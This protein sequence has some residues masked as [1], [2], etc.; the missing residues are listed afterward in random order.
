MMETA[1]YYTFSTIA[2]TL[3]AAIALLAAFLLYRLQTIAH[4]IDQHVNKLVQF[5]GGQ[6]RLDLDELD[7]QGKHD[8]FLAYSR[9]HHTPAV[10][11][12]VRIPHLRL[13]ALL[14]YRRAI[15][16][17]FYF[18]LWLTVGLVAGSVAVLVFTPAIGN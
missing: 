18:S 12:H 4:A 15:F 11:E 3:A 14:T 16:R 2:Q 10:V 6:E 9:Q 7:A 5:F 1:L 17:T 13:A 8:E